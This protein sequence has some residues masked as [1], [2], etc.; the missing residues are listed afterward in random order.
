[1]KKED[2]QL[3]GR[4]IFSSVPEAESPFTKVREGHLTDFSIGYR[5]V[6]SIWVPEETTKKIKGH[7]FEGPLSVATRWRVKELSIVPIGADEDARVRNETRNDNILEEP[8]MDEKFREYLESIGL[9]REATEDEAWAFA[10]TL[11]AP[12]EKEKRDEEKIDTDKIRAEATGEER[13]RIREIDAMCKRYE[14]SDMADDLVREGTPILEAREKVLTRAE[15]NWVEKETKRKDRPMIEIGKDERDKFR[16]AVGDAL[17]LRAGMEIEKPAPGAD[18]LRGYTMVEMARLC[19][20]NANEKT[21]GNVMEMVGRAMT[22]SDFPY[23]LANVAHKTLFEGWNTQEET[24]PIWC[25]TGSV[26]DFKT[27][28]SPRISEADDLEEVPEEGEYRYG[29]RTEAQESYSV[30]T[31]GK[32]Y[33]ITRQAIINDDLNALSNQ[34]KAHGEAAARKVGDVAYAVLTANAAMGDAVA[35]FHANHSN[36]VDHASGAAP[37]ISTIAAGVLAMKN[38]TD[39]RGLRSLNIQ[40]RFMLA[41]N[42]LEGAAE[43][44]FRSER[45]SDASTIATDSSMASTQVNPYA[46]TYLTRVYDGRLDDNDALQWYLAAAKGKTVIVFFLNGIKKPYL[47]TKKGWSVD[48]VE[49]KVRIDAGA[50]AMDWRGLYENDGN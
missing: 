38:Q 31:Y 40:P 39:L 30:V 34:P 16:A 49:Y 6:G 50:K 10:G 23:L 37:G 45:F 43:V 13:S 42:A 35:L 48:G 3:V 21:A 29:K 44:F 9:T 41:P 1:M 26:S 33:A 11:Q 15:E 19:L 12:K 27:H 32:L 7:E 36:F 4:A 17:T 46:G 8:K 22:V 2:D 47:E 18:E 24:W 25:G 5:V 28:Y 14:L 20:R